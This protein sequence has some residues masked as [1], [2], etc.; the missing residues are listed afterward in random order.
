MTELAH[1]GMPRRSGRYPWGS[2]EN[3]YQNN[4]NFLGYLQDMRK[5]GLSEATIAKG[6]G[7]STTELRAKKSIARAEM[8]QSEIAMVQRLKDKG[9]SNVAIGNRLGIPEPTVRNRLAPGAA[10]R[11]NVLNTTAEVLKA[12]V[13]KGGYIQIGSGVEHHLGI[14]DNQLKNSV[15]LLREQGYQVQTV[16]I[17]QL[18]TGAGKKTLIKVLVPA[19][20]SYVDVK[21]N[22]DNIKMPL[23][24]SDDKGRTYTKITAPVSVDSKRVQV[25]YANQG[26]AAEDGVIYLREGAPD[27]SMG[28]SRY[29]QVRI[30]VDGTHYLKGMAV[31]KSDLPDGVDIVFNTNKSSTG[32]PKDAMKEFGSDPDNPFGS[33]ITRQSGPLNIVNEAGVWENWSNTLSSQ[34]LSKQSPRLASRQLDRLAERNRTNLDEIKE[35]TNPAVKRRLLESFADSADSSAVHLEAAAL[36]RQSTHVLL[37]VNSLKNSEVYAPNYNNGERVALIRY[38]HGG[39]FEIPDLTV[40]NNNR[41]AKNLMGRARDAIGINSNVA[42]RLSGA[43]FD[44]DTV[45]VIPNNNGQV[46]S[47]PALRGLKD[48][49][50]QRAY[51]GYEGMKVMSEPEK[52]TLM[53]DV[54]NLITDMTIRKASPDELAQAVRH[55]MVVIDAAKHGLDFRRSA[56]ENKIAD[57]KKKYQ[58]RANAGASTLISRATSRQDVFKRTPRR[59][60]EGGPIDPETGKLVFTPTTESYVN[61]QGKTVQPM[62][63][64]T[65]L[66]ETDDARTLSSGT[67]IESIY[68]DH[69]NRLKAMANEA[70]RELVRTKPITYSP[71]A[72]KVYAPEVR[73]LDAALKIALSNRPLE[74]QAQILATS[75]VQMRQAHDPSMDAATL[76]KVKGQ[77]LEKARARVGAKKN[78][79][80]ISPREWEAIQAGAISNHKLEQILRNADIDRVR[81]LATPKTQQGMSAGAIARARSMLA[82]GATQAEVAAALGVS[83]STIRNV[84]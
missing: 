5:K 19:G 41:E 73:R 10:D 35:L 47:S 72:N 1:Y 27:L 11:A 53:G 9:Y 83:V 25:R 82:G 58:G 28:S 32:N 61:R 37:P 81:Q 29:A 54:S 26:G 14:S 65:K 77:E 23:A 38:P 67:L 75:Q 66:A 62:Q 60:S 8:I 21:N 69:S 64:S 76:R 44:G 70:R 13:D 40:N 56:K 51:P 43:D 24:N 12:E 22:M 46:Q 36:P 63:R 3:P 33:S 31:Y 16:Q 17:D 55:S 78:Q 50:P 79:I 2:G 15:A 20:V 34:M 7:M 4:K 71:S 84:L 18:G 39:T 68:A 6:L 42:Q 52:Q 57:L 30:G 48:F 49:D 59:A 80:E 45:L 74:R